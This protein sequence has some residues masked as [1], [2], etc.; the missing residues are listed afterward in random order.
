MLW[1]VVLRI[2]IVISTIVVDV[3]SACS[4]WIYR[5]SILI[6]GW[7]VRL[8]IVVV[9]RICRIAIII[10]VV[11]GRIRWIDRIVA[12]VRWLILAVIYILGW[13]SIGTGVRIRGG[14]S[15]GRYTGLIVVGSVSVHRGD[16]CRVVL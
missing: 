10:V 15:V 16:A 7:F 11:G 2:I 5:V 13:W 9:G 3:R 12:G 14:V 8:W 6:D 1:H 4:R